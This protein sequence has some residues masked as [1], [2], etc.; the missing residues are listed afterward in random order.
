MKVLTAILM[1]VLIIGV[2]PAFATLVTISDQTANSM[3]AKGK[4]IGMEA[5]FLIEQNKSGEIS[6]NNEVSS[7]TIDNLS[8]VKKADT[9]G[10]VMQSTS[11]NC[12]PA[13]LAT[14]LNNLGINATEQELVNLAGTDEF[15]TTMQGLMQAAQSKGIKANG[16]KL[17]TDELKKDNIVFLN[18]DGSTHYSV[19]K[20]VTNKSVK[21]ADPSL[22]NIEMPKEM[23]NEVYSG[24]AL[25]IS[26][27]D[28]ATGDLNDS[29]ENG[30]NTDSNTLKLG[31]NSTSA[32]MLQDLK[33]KGKIKIII[34][35]LK[36]GWVFI[37]N[38]SVVACLLSIMPE[39]WKKWFYG[40]INQA[41]ANYKSNQE[42][43]KKKYGIEYDPID[44][45]VTI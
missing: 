23:F 37:S 33:G 28:L 31:N 4:G 39:S 3:V 10:I 11:Y 27:L 19:V 2:T 8:S 16:M 1:M 41:Y 43:M 12:G 25:V 35:F 6:K 30:I 32:K 21:L 14:V 40:T 45:C 36:N 17:S 18:V 7:K 5:I 15:G 22:G 34:R 20:G 9:T 26:D 44:F 42:V 24:N 29:K 13:A 38:I